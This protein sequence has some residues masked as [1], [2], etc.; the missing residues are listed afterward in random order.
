MGNNVMETYAVISGCLTA[1]LEIMGIRCASR[2]SSVQLH[3]AMR[4]VKLPCFLAH[5]RNE[6]MVHGRKLIG[7]AQKR[8]ADAVIQHGSMPLDPPY[9][10][11]PDYLLISDQQRAVQKELLAVKS[12]CLSEIDSTWQR[13]SIRRAI[14]E[15][16]ISTLHMEAEEMGWKKEEIA[17][18]E[19]IGNSKNFRETWLAV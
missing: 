12:A 9:R 18:I 7:S 2:Y 14:I 16:F 10:T 6:I 17:A 19:A 13:S 3:K 15:G 11:L 8:T 1:G 4:E 5:S